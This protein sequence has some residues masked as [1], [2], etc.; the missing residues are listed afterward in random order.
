[1]HNFSALQYANKNAPALVRNKA[2][3]NLIN[4]YRR[5]KGHH[6]DITSE[7]WCQIVP[8]W[9]LST[10]FSKIGGILPNC[11]S[12]YYSNVMINSPP[13]RGDFLKSSE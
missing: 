6:N 10:D 7:R 8:I 2:K 1:M 3:S 12:W 4:S 9:P 5:Q 13:V 11:W